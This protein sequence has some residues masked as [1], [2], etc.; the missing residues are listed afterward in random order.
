M[1]WL[2]LVALVRA[3]ADLHCLSNSRGALNANVVFVHG[4]GGHPFRTWQATL[5]ESTLWPRWLA[6][7]IDGLA[8]WSV[9]YEAP[10]SRLQGTAMGLLDRGEN[11]L[12]R[13]INEPKLKDGRIILIG[14]SLGGLVIK[15]LLQ[16][17]EMEARNSA[18]AA[19][20]FERIDKV[21]FLATPHTGAD[22]AVWGDRLRIL[23]RPSAATMCLVRN[24]P[25]LRGLNN[26]YRQRAS[27]I[28]VLH[29]VLRE[30][31]PI[32]ILGTIVK[33]DTAD[34]ALHRVRVWP[35]DHDHWS[36]AKPT[37]RADEVYAHVRQFILDPFERPKPQLETLAEKII[38]GQQ[39]LR[40]DTQ[41]ILNLLKRSELGSDISIIV[42]KDTFEI[43]FPNSNEL[44]P[45]PELELPWQPLAS[46]VQ[47]GDYNLLDALRWNFGLVEKLYGRDDELN[48]IV[49]W[50]ER[51]SAP[52]SARLVT[53]D[54]GSGKTRLAAASAKALRERGWTAGFL[55]SG[56]S[57]RIDIGSAKG[58]F[59]ILD[60]PEENL[61]LMR[62]LIKTL[63]ATK[64]AAYPIRLLLLSRRDFEH[65]RS[66]TL[67]LEGRFGNHPIAAPGDLSLIDVVE[68]IET[69]AINF[70]QHAGLPKPR[71]DRAL[72]WAK[73]TPLHRLPLMAAAA[74]V[75]AVLAPREAFGIEGG[76]I[77][78]DLAERERVRVR[79]TSDRLGI[80]PNTLGRLLALGIV[81]NGL[82]DQ[83]IERLVDADFCE[84]VSKSQI[85]RKVA[86]TPWWRS[87]RL[88]RLAPDRIAAA[89][90]A[91]ELFDARFPDGDQMLPIWLSIALAGTE[92]GFANR[93][94]R[95]LFDMDAPG[96]A[97]GGAQSLESQLAQIIER[98][99]AQAVRFA[100]LASREVPYGAAGF[101]A[102][103][104]LALAGLLKDEPVTQAMFLNN[105]SNFL[106]M[107]GRREEAL[108]AA[109]DAANLYRELARVQRE[110]FMPNLAGSL[111]NL[112]NKLSEVGHHEEALAAATEAAGLFRNLVRS[113]PEAFTF[114]LAVSL[115]TLANRFSDLGQREDAL[116]VATE[117]A[118]L[119][120]ELARAQPEAFTPH[121]AISLN[122]LAN[123]LSDLGRREEA[124]AAA[125]EAVMIRRELARTR[126]EVF[127]P[128]L[129]I[130]LN[131]LANMLSNI[132]RREEAL[133]AATEAVTIQRD[134]VRA[135]PEV[136][137]PDLAASLNNLA[138]AHSQLGQNEGALAASM[139]AVGLHRDLAA[140]RPEV[141]TPDL[142][143]SLNNLVGKF[144]GLGQFEEAL[145][146]ATEAV[147]IQ[148]ELARARPEAFESHLA[149]SLG[150]LANMFSGLGQR[151]EALAAAAEA[152]GLYRDLARARPEVFT[153]GLAGSFHNLASM[154][155]GLGR[156]G[157]ALAASTEAAELYRGLARAQP[158]AFTPNLAMALNNLATMLS[159]LGRREEE[160]AT[161]T[162]AAG[163]YRDLARV[164]SEAFTPGLAV[165]LDNLASILTELGRREDALAVSTEAV[166]IQRELIRVRPDVFKPDLARSLHNLANTLSELGRRED[167][168]AAATEAV[169]MLRDLARARPQVF[170]FY[171]A[172][173]LRN[174][175]NILSGLG[176]REEALAAEQEA[177]ALV[178]KK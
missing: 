41:K 57:L 174:L 30:T 156:H 82:N 31:K 7:D 161:A 55:K 141:F 166:T 134:L 71:L 60:Y 132:G 90:L 47:P 87:G 11:I 176:R 111:N 66:E 12:G 75:H 154:L 40:S 123:M 163:F 48:K 22:L 133:A 69:A 172:M 43:G 152:V 19:S 35:T 52:P 17:L 9:G 139:E 58:L 98:D 153:A 38:G 77:V 100:S 121:L 104:A 25:A 16:I 97:R 165:S 136:F 14:H 112:A 80:G 54:G 115:S 178:G 144:A 150:N 34:P 88:T 49:A 129:G 159:E 173:S 122:N 72:D 162:E 45:S 125:T 50:A 160:L 116:V 120:R 42:G 147:T 151:E 85:L 143:K 114:N 126:P 68:L 155:S 109:T 171:L 96:V 175:A 4:L 110:E 13:L 70:S 167:A 23:V 93:L 91:A 21:A 20:L 61:D 26:W 135:R 63:A 89:F 67:I 6:K 78:R 130:S 118:G 177:K 157:E 107:L 32:R 64:S 92:D 33:P 148:R 59:L 36:I 138:H 131:N 146:A 102:V 149:M 2:P 56:E 5:D 103:I 18:A 76:A 37:S 73:E 137:A 65:W 113:R 99:P 39:E 27:E 86:D 108:T 28:G 53:G 128:D 164:R 62:A 79:R 8:V 119:Y 142:A 1:S 106:S 24:D 46:A 168:L 3:V 95:I 105:A 51:T 84:G 83:A 127:T 169:A 140:V 44:S 81:G 145:A 124:L 74:A 94:G 170:T 29:L 117:A 15:Q 158:E 101:A 10:I